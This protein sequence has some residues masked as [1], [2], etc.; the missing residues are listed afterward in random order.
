MPDVEDLGVPLVSTD[1]QHVTEAPAHLAV[2]ADPSVSTDGPVTEAQGQTDPPI[3]TAGK[4]L[5]Q[6]VTEAPA[7]LA[8]PAD[9][10]V[11]TDGLVTEAQG[12][13]DPPISTAGENLQTELPAIVPVPTLSYGDRGK[14]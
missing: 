10:S 11:L 2:P 5:E 6:S 8:V 4:N 3:S 9:P 12:Q 1:E 14:V 7:L 13:T